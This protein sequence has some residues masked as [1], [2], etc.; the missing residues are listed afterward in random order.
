MP[1]GA[2][3]AISVVNTEPYTLNIA[4]T[5]P[6]WTILDR[7]GLYSKQKPLLRTKRSLAYQTPK[8]RDMATYGCMH[9]Y[10][11]V[12]PKNPPR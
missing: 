1:D 9:L 11:N 3:V 10:T 4:R 12:N 8:I 5:G 2:I 7:T 6:Y